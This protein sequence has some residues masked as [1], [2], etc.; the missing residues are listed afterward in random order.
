MK[1]RTPQGRSWPPRCSRWRCRPARASRAKA[2]A[3]AR[4]PKG[5]GSDR[6]PTKPDMRFPVEVAPVESQRVEYTVTAV[7]SVEAF[8]RVQVTARV[9]GVVERVR[10]REGDTVTPGTVLVEIEPQR[11]PRRGHL[12]ARPR[13][14]RPRRARP[15]PRPGSRAARGGREAPGPHPRRGAR[16]LPHQGAT[17]GRGRSSPQRAGRARAGAAQ[18]ARRLRARADRPA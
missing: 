1:H 16:D 12:G 6:P 5:P 17:L 2:T 14:R 11:Y 4:P 15:R 18:P 8:E 9:A 3:R 10:F 13:S 7:G